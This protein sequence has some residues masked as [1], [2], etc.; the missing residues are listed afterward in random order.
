MDNREKIKRLKENMKIKTKLYELGIY[1]IPG[2]Q[3][4]KGDKGTSI[5]LKG[6]Y[7]SFDELVLN[8]PVGELGDTY[9][10]DGELYYWDENNN[11]SSAGSIK[12]EKG[13]QGAK[14]KKEI[15]VRKEKKVRKETKA[16]Q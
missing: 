5:K 16:K 2:P 10:V 6:G 8:H 14:E 13:E 1:P 9:V 11:W 4:S 15:P 12:G 7:G 3:G